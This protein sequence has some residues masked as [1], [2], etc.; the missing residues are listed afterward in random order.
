MAVNSP[1]FSERDCY[2]CLVDLEKWL[3]E[4]VTGIAIPKGKARKRTKKTPVTNANAGPTCAGEVVGYGTK[5][6]WIQSL[7]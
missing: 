3:G 2:D 5:K 4:R 6:D 7:S 1:G